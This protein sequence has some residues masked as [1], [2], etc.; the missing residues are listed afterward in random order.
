MADQDV[1]ELT[2]DTAPALT[3]LLYEVEDPAGTPADKSVSINDVLALA[4]DYVKVS[5]VK[6]YNVNAG[7]FTLGAW[8][9]RDINTEDNDTGNVCSIAG[10]QITLAAGT[11]ECS[12]SCPSYA[13]SRNV[14]RFYNITDGSVELTGQ[15][16]VAGSVTNGTQGTVT[17]VGRFTIAAQKVFEIQHQS[18]LT[19]ATYGLGLAHNF[20]GINNVYT[21]A[22]FRR[23][24]V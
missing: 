14:A 9:T 24:R 23:V 8:R 2:Q 20:A 15:S 13:V 22:E 5:D 4:W 19:V 10:N 17:V 21:V 16:S 3:D 6:A 18:Q 1:T 11:Y 12:M 7:T